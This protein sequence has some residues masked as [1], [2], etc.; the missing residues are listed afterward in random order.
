MSMAGSVARAARRPIGRVMRASSYP[1]SPPAPRPSVPPT[2]DFRAWPAASSPTRSSPTSGPA[3]RTC[4]CWTT[5]STAPRTS[6]TRRPTCRPACRA[7]SPCRPRPRRSPS[8]SGSVP[9]TTSRSSRAAPA[10]ACRGGA[11]G[12]E[13][14]LTIAFTA[15]DRILEIDRE[16]LCVV[17]Q[18]GIVNAA[19][20]AAVAAHGLFYAPD[21]GELRDV[22]DRWQ[23]GHQ[24][25]RPVLREVRPDPRLRPGPGG[26]AGRRHDP[27]DRRQEH[28]GRGRLLADPPHRRLA[29]DAG[30]RHGG[31]PA[32]APDPAAAV[33]AAR[34]LPEPRVGR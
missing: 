18:P 31:D 34:V 19:L 2:V 22:H 10:P 33:H 25:R 29:G 11:T 12:I 9:R 7:P 23:P 30:D 24:R 21:P 15:M 1:R 16:N 20:K 6:A 27:A 13:G 28:Q 32:P 3:C 4:A 8:S 5:P 17:T 26:R 14:A